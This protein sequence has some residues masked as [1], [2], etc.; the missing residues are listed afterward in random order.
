MRPDCTVMEPRMAATAALEIE[1]PIARTRA[2]SPLAEA[3]SVIGTDA[4]MIVGIADKEKEPPTTRG[5]PREPR[6]GGRRGKNP[7]PEAR[8]PQ[9]RPPRNK[10]PPPAV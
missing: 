9:A 7:P 1:V 5:V 2:L 10:G 8:E 6:W 4:M 3:V